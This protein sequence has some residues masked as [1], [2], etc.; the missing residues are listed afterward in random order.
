MKIQFLGT[1]EA[2][3]DRANTS[4]LI[5]DQIL[6]DCGPTTVQQLMKL[7]FDLER[8]EI[9]YISH[10]HAD[11]TFGLPAL[12]VASQE[13]GRKKDLEIYGLG[14]LTEYL[15]N[16]L[17]L[18]YKKSLTDLGFEV[19]IHEIGKKEEINDYE[20]SFGRCKH[21]IPCMSISVTKDKKVIYTGDGAPTRETITLAQNSDL[22]IAEAYMEG[23]KMHSSIL[24]AARLA[25]ESNSKSLAL[26]HIC[27]KE[28]MKRVKDAKKIFTPI[29][30]PADLDI[31]E[32]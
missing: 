25:K 15:S 5:D 3:S 30:V 7:K 16:L 29:I 2:F 21:S 24:G 26:V 8:I 6:L 18:A 20:F 14:G 10:F 23:F 1:G 19:H 12:L 27:R 11:H 32:L 28:N 31:I 22:L 17:Y 9:L 13:D 4:I